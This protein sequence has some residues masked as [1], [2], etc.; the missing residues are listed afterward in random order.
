[1][2]E[3]VFM[4]LNLNPVMS[5]IGNVPAAIASTIVACRAVRRLSNY[6]SQGPEV[7]ASTTQGSTLAFRSG[8]GTFLRANKVSTKVSTHPPVEGVHVQ[9]ET[10]ESPSDK[11]YNEY[12]AA[13]QIVKSDNFDPEAQN[14]SNDFKRPPY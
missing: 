14:I 6:T 7:F 3:Q 8:A 5:I 13:G 2:P 4:L 9:M 12:D 10:F 1:M 11:S